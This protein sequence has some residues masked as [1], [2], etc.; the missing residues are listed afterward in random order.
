MSLREYNRKRKFS[1][2]PEPK[3]NKIEIKKKKAE[4]NKKK[5]IFVVHQHFASHL[6]W[7]LRL[8]MDGVLKSWA[9][10]KEPP[11]KKNVKRLAIQVEDHPLEYA[12][13]EGII[14]EGNYGAGK[15]KI[16]DTGKYE[17][18]NK[19]ANKIEFNLRGKK[20]N[21]M[22]ILIKTSYGNK[23]GKSWLWFKI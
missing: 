4:L 20:L 13:F 22:Y 17:L 18:K 2:T 3:K 16:W 21:G 14:P 12:K 7:D 5:L 19:S 1:K 15:V 8:E 23:P 10:P 9:V 11:R 6:H